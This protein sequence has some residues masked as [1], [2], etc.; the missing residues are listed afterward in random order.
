MQKI[1][2]EEEMRGES[3]VGFNTEENNKINILNELKSVKSDIRGI[4][5]V[6]IILSVVII[7]S[8]FLR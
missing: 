5:I 8:K 4:Y 7:M 6:I 3:R 1:E 2:L